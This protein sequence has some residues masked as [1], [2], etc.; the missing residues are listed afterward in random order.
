MKRTAVRV[1]ME[2]IQDLFDLPETPYFAEF[3]AKTNTVDFFYLGGEYEAAAGMECVISSPQVF[4]E[5]YQY[6]KQK[7]SKEKES[8]QME[9]ALMSEPHF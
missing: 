1:S 2:M 4:D 5:K 7:I 3:N 8:C 6:V 9:L